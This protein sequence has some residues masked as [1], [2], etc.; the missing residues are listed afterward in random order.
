MG[1]PTVIGN[2][3]CSQNPG[4]YYECMKMYCM[5]SFV[6]HSTPSVSFSKVHR[7]LLNHSHYGYGSRNEEG[8]TVLDICKF[9]RLRILNTYFEKEEE[10]LVTYK[11]GV[12]K[13]QIDLLLLR[14]AGGIQCTDCHAIPGE[15]YISQHRPVRACISVPNFEMRR[16][17]EIKRI[18]LWKLKDEE[19]RNECQEKLSRCMESCHG[20][21]EKLEEHLLRICREDCGETTGRRGR[22]RETWWWNDT[23]QQIIKEKKAAFRK[24]QRSGAEVDKEVYKR[25]RREAQRMVGDVKKEAWSQWCQDLNTR[26]GRNKLF[27]VASQMK[28]DKKDIQG[29]GFIK[30]ENGIIL[31]EQNEVAERWRRYFQELLNEEYGNQI[32]E[33]DVVE[34]P[35]ENIAEEEVRTAISKMKDKR[36]TGPS[37]VSSE[38]LKAMEGVG[39]KEVT[40]ALQQIVQDCRMPDSWKYSTTIALFKGKGDALACNKYRGLRLLEHGM[41]IMEKV[42]DSKL[43]RITNIGSSQ[44]G[45]QPGKST[46]DA[47]FI[48]RQLQEK[49][50]QKK[51]KLYHVFVDLEKAFD[52]IPRRA[53]EWA[54]RR[55]L[56]PERLVQLVMMM[57]ADTRS[58]VGVAGVLS[59]DFPIEVGVHQGSALSPLLFIL[60]IEEATKECGGG[61]IWELLY[62]DDLVLTAESK[63]EVE[64]KFVDWKQ[65]M[66][67]RGMKVNIGKSK[68]MVTGKRNEVIRS[69]RYPC[70]V[71]GRG[72]GQNSILCTACQLWCHK[73]CSGLARLGGNPNFLCPTCAGQGDRSVEEESEDIH[74]GGEVI[75]E[76]EEFCYLGDLLDREGGV[77][78]TVRMRVSAA[79]RKWREISGLLVNRSVPVVCRARVYDACI[80]SVML[81]GS[82]GW[83]MLDRLRGVLTSCDRR[84]LRYIA[85]VS[86]LDHVRSEEVADRCGVEPLEVVMRRRRLRWYGHVRRRDEQEPLGRIME[87]TVEGR[88]PPGRPKKS[89]RKTVEEDM[90]HVGAREED[91]L[92]RARWKHL[93]TRQTP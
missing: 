61:S 5:K 72:V 32:E 1:F 82:E 49:Y 22:E 73:R 51:R 57:Y 6:H 69:G 50:L 93:I 39:V 28:K 38:M 2:L 25:K 34:G 48:V 20:E 12:H 23:V 53:I 92:D 19:K 14:R 16:K 66:A 46:E 13:T 52:R 29:S 40:A 42:L 31:V 70:G 10:K 68:I 36:A 75:E 83:P 54:L 91:A 78:R 58:R 87:L 21:M 24:W 3:G 9:H 79:W 47:V 26:E 30:D 45:F 56:V 80:R 71:C 90:R 85:A 64:R 86:L 89:W 35:I 4:M 88:R 84:M 77:E 43:R 8:S 62:A 7:N 55:Q 18:K 37:G 15:E 60:V 76:V 44:F 59:E 11:S 65:A 33:C 81:Y 27:R 41:K 67:R 17:R 74:I 63:E